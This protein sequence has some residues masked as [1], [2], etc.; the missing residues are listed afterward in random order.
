[1]AGLEN[2]AKTPDQNNR[3]HL[4]LIHKTE[5]ALAGS[6]IGRDR[7]FLLEINFSKRKLYNCHWRGSGCHGI[8]YQH[9]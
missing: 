4:T 6:M 8:I 2:D 9:Y 3:Y 5:H 7:R 1:M